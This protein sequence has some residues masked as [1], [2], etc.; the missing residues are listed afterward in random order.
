MEL[1]FFGYR[2]FTAR[3]DRILARRGLGRTHHRVLYFVGRNPG[4]SVGGLLDILAVSK[5][6]LNAPL[7]QLTEMKLIVLSPDPEDRRVRRLELTP[8]GQSLEAELTGAQM[9]F[10]SVAFDKAGAANEA[11]WTRVMETLDAR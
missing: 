10:L 4:I 6:A 7:R 3:G 2:E 8:A 5:Q 11:G 1:L 9:R